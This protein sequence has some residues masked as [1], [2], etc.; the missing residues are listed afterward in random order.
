MFSNNARR[1][2]GVL[3]GLTVCLMAPACRTSRGLE[4]A[5]GECPASSAAA[6]HTLRKLNEII[7]PEMTFFAPATIIDAVDFLK[8]ASREYDKP[9]VPPEKRGV[10]IVV[11]LPAAAVQGHLEAVDPF[12]AGTS[13]NRTFPAIHALSVRAVS[14]YDALKLVCAVTDMKLRVTQE[15]TVEIYPQSWDLEEDW[16]TRSY[17][18]PEALSTRLFGPAKGSGSD[19]DPNK[20]WQAFF[21][22]LG[23][24][25]PEFAKFEYLPAIGKLRVTNTTEN[26]AVIEMVFEQFALRMIEVEMQIQA[27]RARDI[28]RLRLAGGVTVE[29]LMEL[30]RNG[31]ARPVATATALTMSGQEAVVKAVREVLYPTELNSGIN[32]D[33]TNVTARIAAG[34]LMPGNVEVR[35]TGMVLQVIPEVTHNGAWINLMLNPKWVTLEGWDAFPAALAAGWTH[36]TLALRQPVFGETSFQTQATVADGAT[37]LLG[38][39]S[40]PDGEWVQAGFL[41]VRLRDVNT[42]PSEPLRG[43][44]KRADPSA[45][46]IKEKM[47]AVI[48]PE[49]NFRPPATIIDAVAFFAKASRDSDTPEIPEA[50]RGFSFALKLPESTL[51][52]PSAN[53]SADPFAPSA[54][55]AT[56]NSVPVISALSARFITLYDALKLVCDV[57]GMKFR[58][59][60]GIIWIEPLNEPDDELVTRLYLV[61]ESLSERMGGA[62]NVHRYDWKTFFGQMG[63]QWPTGSSLAYLEAV[64][65]CRVT[66]TPEN[67]A[68]LEQVL[69][70]LVI[71]PLMVETEVQIHAFR[72]EDVERLRLSGDVSVESLTVLRQKGRSRPVAS[73]SVLTRSGQEAVMKSV[74]E[75]IYPTELDGR[76][77]ASGEVD[78]ALCPSDFE[79]RETGMILQVV[80]EISATDYSQIGLLLNPQ[81]ITLDGWETHPA[82]LA[83][84]WRASTVP[85]RLPLL[86]VTSFQTQVTVKDGGTVLLGSTSTPDGKWVQVGF[87]MA[88]R[89]NVQSEASGNSP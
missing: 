55:P 20:V 12:A 24:T 69:V 19:A 77:G 51:N 13:T 50:R 47:R 22:Q 46:K 80:A 38:S 60:D 23:V 15:G 76:G 78:K 48:L 32:G 44:E 17:V 5:V 57:A 54:V 41:T 11:K 59:R 33:G 88:R 7:I 42:G 4:Q 82:A 70:D 2:L 89:I 9:G 79:M 49:I 6:D 56:T 40:T 68:V 58:I 35:E 34:A 39:C 53:D 25:G 36:K 43:S 75:V 29:T 74:Q 65:R 1:L 83:G 52:S 14:L 63:V 45:A 72:S 10:S 85:L 18:I 67:L 26:L 31:K 30:R 73:A 71:P 27:F 66:N 16:C 62:D 81:W 64:G 61:Q 37:I 3:L 21:E 87:L 84:R 8:Q 28:E 86:E